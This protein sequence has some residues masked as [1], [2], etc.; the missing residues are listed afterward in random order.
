MPDDVRARVL[1]TVPAANPPPKLYP[2]WAAWCM[3]AFYDLDTCRSVGFDIGPIPWTAINAWAI[4]H[5]L[6][7]EVRRV[8]VAVVR[9]MD[10]AWLQAERERIEAD[11]RKKG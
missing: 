3:A 9:R 4:E 10:A 1:A 11:A 2:S 5:G 8:F 6:T 7:G